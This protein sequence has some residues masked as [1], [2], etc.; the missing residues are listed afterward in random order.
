MKMK[1][2]QKTA[3]W[4]ADEFIN[5][6]SNFD[7]IEDYLRFVKKEVLSSRTS[8]VSLSDEFFTARNNI[9]KK[10]EKLNWKNGFYR[11]DI[12]YKVIN[13]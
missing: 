3:E 6:F 8:L 1:V 5:Y 9:I 12:G 13:K 4:A 2:T 11:K 7:D 10:L